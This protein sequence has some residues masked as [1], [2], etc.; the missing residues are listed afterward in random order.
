MSD[1]GTSLRFVARNPRPRVTAART[2]DEINVRI[3]RFVKGDK[4]DQGDKGDPGVAN[5]G[6]F[7]II[8]LDGSVLVKN[9]VTGDVS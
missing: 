7:R 3:A 5:A 8:G 6:N 4:G 2:D 9:A 1:D